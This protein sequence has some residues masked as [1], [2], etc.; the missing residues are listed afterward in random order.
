MPRKAIPEHPDLAHER[1]KERWAVVFGLGTVGILY[2]LIT[3]GF[4]ANAE[5]Y[6]WKDRVMPPNVRA[7]INQ[8]YLIGYLFIAAGIA[9][10]VGSYALWRRLRRQDNPLLEA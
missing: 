10:M 3:V 8:E 5:Y 4:A 1:R 9:A 2:G 6:Y 7:S